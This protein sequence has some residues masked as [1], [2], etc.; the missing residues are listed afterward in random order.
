[1]KTIEEQK[2]VAVIVRKLPLV[3]KKEDFVDLLRKKDLTP[4]WVEELVEI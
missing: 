3:A 4:I 1:M 2:W